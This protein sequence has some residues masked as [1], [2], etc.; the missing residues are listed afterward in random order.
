MASIDV[1]VFDLGN[2]L[3]DL[4]DGSYLKHILNLPE[5]TSEADAW[6]IWLSSLAVKR[7]DS[8]RVS[9]SKF[10]EQFAEET[11]L[12]TDGNF[13]ERFKAWP[14]APFEGVDS[15]LSQLPPNLH[16]AVLSNTNSAHW[17][18]LMD[19]MSL[20]G[21][22]HSYFASHLTGFVK[23]ESDIYTHMLNCLG[24]NGERVLF[25]DDNQIN[26]DGARACGIC[27]EKAK[28]LDQVKQ[29]LA[30]YHIL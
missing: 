18:R 15:L 29:V 2:V 6:E 5:Q 7:F 24:V 12:P 9:L 4:G 16:L 27:S 13:E 8:G 19:E 3:I 1:L 22:F 28:G 30:Q 23:P 21:R 26:V 25:I 17:P 20:S 10:L 11:G 14:K